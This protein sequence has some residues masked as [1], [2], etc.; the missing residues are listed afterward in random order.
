MGETADSERAFHNEAIVHGTRQ[1]LAPVYSITKTAKAHYSSR[2]LDDVA[3]LDVLE[4]GPGVGGHLLRLARKGAHVTAVDISEEAVKRA[5][6]SVDEA[7]LD[8]NVLLMDAHHLE[9][10]D[11]SFDRVCG[12]GILHHLD[13]TIAVPEVARVLRPT[14][15]ALFFEPLGHNPAINW[16]RRRTPELRTPDEHPLLM[17]DLERLYDHFRVVETTYF[18]LVS[19]GALAVRDTPLF[20]GAVR[21]GERFDGFLFRF[22]PWLRRYAWIVVIELAKPTRYAP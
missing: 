9:F 17:S 10:G 6:A 1:H 22:A 16:Y 2:T 15:S 3:G 21:L 12:S 19:I 8:A 13:L 11:G 14:G 5:R 7:G 20:A 4:Y 18:H